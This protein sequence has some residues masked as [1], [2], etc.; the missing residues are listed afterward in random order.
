MQ[1]DYVVVGAGTAGCV[2]ASRLAAQDG[3]R[4]ALLEAGPSD[5]TPDSE[6]PALFRRLFKTERDWDF[7]TEPEPALDDRRGYLPRGRMLGGS[8]SLNGMVYIRGN[9]ADFDEW[10]QLGNPGWGYRDVLPYF[11][12]SEDNERGADAYHG[13]GGPLGISDVRSGFEATD[14]WVEAAVQA[15]YA[16]TTD[17]N[18][19]SQEG[20]GRYQVFERG[21]ARASSSRE[22]LPA[23]LETGRLSI[24][25]DA[26]VTRLRV[27]GGRAA[28]VEAVRHGQTTAIEASREI[29]VCAGA[30]QSPQLLMLSGIGPSRHLHEH[31]LECLEDLPVGENL[32]DHPCVMMSFYTRVPGIHSASTDAAR[33]QWERLRSGPLTS[34]MAE[35]GGFVRSRPELDLPDIQFHAGVGAYQDHG[36]GRPGADGQ[37]F[38]PNLAK[39]TSVGQLTLRSS[40][41]TAKPRILHNFLATQSDRDLMLDAMR[42]CLDIA[43]QPALKAIYSGVHRAPAS[44]SDADIMDYVRRACQ[45]NYHPAGTCAM[46]SVVDPQLRVYGVDGLRVADASVFPTMIRGNINAAVV[47]IAEKAADLI[48]SDASTAEP[49]AP[50]ALA[51]R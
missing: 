12:R 29:I 19:A 28:A 26:H 8:S 49:K 20:V 5:D 16:H 24:L 1:F 48:I 11:K 40:V 47:M 4:V 2:L 18:G 30:Y 21:G 31:A 33:D 23:A 45:T 44:R 35:A 27:S 10:E 13:V 17:F 22:F 43:A 9:A 14:A 50:P 36:L 7:D 41:P 37:S 42:I 38:S 34:N 39:P 3:A 15:G 46:G 6:I 32:L 25:T 51:A